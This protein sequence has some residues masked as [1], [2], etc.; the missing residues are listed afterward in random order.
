MYLILVLIPVIII[1]LIV[2]I[3]FGINN[4]NSVNFFQAGV[5]LDIEIPSLR[6]EIKSPDEE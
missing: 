4:P 5:G 6:M 1:A 2:G 3:S